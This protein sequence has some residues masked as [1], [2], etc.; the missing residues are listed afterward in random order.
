MKKVSAGRREE[1]GRLCLELS[2]VLNKLLEHPLMDEEAA[3]HITNG[4]LRL[5]DSYEPTY[6]DGEFAEHALKKLADYC[7]VR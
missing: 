7:G 2:P 6:S 5:T 4:Q 3:T 1:F